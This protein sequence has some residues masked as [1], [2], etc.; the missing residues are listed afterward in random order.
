MHINHK[1]ILNFAA[2]RAPSGV[3]LDYGCGLGETITAG[4]MRGMNIYGVESFY[5]D[6]RERAQASGLIGTRILELG[7]HGEIPFVSC[8]FDG[9]VANMVFEHVENLAAVLCEIRRVLKPNGFLLAIFPSKGVLREGHCGIP[10]AHWL[11][12]KPKLLRGILRTGYAIGLGHYRKEKGTQEEWTDYFA[13]FLSTHCHYRTMP[14]ISDAFAASGF[15]MRGIERDYVR[16]RLN[17][18]RL[19]SLAK[20][21]P[22]QLPLRLLATTVLL[23]TPR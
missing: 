12:N 19:A 1:F 6:V 13:N 10:F 9:V 4:L 20:F 8:T 22:C 2:R 3:I 7:S 17:G 14:E 15:S 23:S 11:T 16:Y 21:L 5:A 18:S